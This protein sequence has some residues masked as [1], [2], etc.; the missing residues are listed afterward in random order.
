MTCAI[1]RVTSASWLTA[2]GFSGV[3]TGSQTTQTE[4]HQVVVLPTPT[5]TPSIYTDNT[6]T[7]IRY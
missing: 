3:T 4:R 1:V 5:D 6:D 2:T 7:S